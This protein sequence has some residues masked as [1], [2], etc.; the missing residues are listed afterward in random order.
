MPFCEECD[1]F[2][3][4]FQFVL[5]GDKDPRAALE[6]AVV[7]K[8]DQEQLVESVSAE[9]IGK[10]PDAWMECHGEAVMDLIRVASVGAPITG[11]SVKLSCAKTGPAKA[12]RAPVSIVLSFMCH[13]DRLIVRLF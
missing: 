1:R 9:D 10:L 4:A 11:R 3:P 6:S 12:A 7:T 8:R 13:P 2:Y 5:W